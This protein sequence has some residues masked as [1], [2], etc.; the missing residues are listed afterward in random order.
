MEQYPDH[1]LDLRGVIIPLTLLKVTQAFRDMK[2]GETL[3]ILSG[4][5]ETRKEIFQVLN[6]SNF[7]LIGIKEESEFYCIQLRKDR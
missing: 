3:E 1:H 7:Q 6:A 2:Q 4:D 5:P